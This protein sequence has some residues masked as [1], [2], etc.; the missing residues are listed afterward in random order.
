MKKTVHVIAAVYPD[1]ARAEVT[2]DQL[3]RMHQAL[4]ITL[5]DAAVITKDEHA[6][7]RVAETNEVTPP[8]GALRGAIAGAVIGLIYPP[9]VVAAATAGAAAG[10]L[11]G[12]SR[13]TGI[14]QNRLTEITN[15]LEAGQAAVIALAEDE[16]VLPI[17]QALVALDGTLIT[18]PLDQETQKELYD[19][20]ALGLVTR[21]AT[22]TPPVGAGAQGTPADRLERVRGG[23]TVLDA[24]GETVGNVAYVKLGDPEATTVDSVEPANPMDEAVVLALG[25]HREP[26]VPD[27][28]ADRLLRGGYIKID[29]RRPLRPVHTYYASAD[30]IAAVFGES[31]RL[32]IPRNELMTAAS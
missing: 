1:K 22:V 7:T 9:T 10:A 3:E 11:A 14:K 29:D 13:D 2:I 4:T 30:A 5:L 25:G 26:D 23:M 31:V 17:Q 16:S 18:E 24:T 20:K 15:R 12:G 27:D 8:K 28:L 19:A 32:T 6:R 21:D